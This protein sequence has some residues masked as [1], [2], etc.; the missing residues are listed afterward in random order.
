MFN[1]SSVHGPIVGREK[2]QDWSRIALVL[3]MSFCAMAA[4]AQEQPKYFEQDVKDSNPLR[5]EQA[6]EL[7]EYILKL[8]F[9]QSRLKKL[10]PDDYS[11]VAAYE[12]SAERYRQAF[13]D[14]IGYPPPGDVPSTE[15]SFRQIGEDSLG[16][17]YRVM[18]PVL[19][20]VHAEGIYIIPKS[21][22][23][24]E[25]APLI[26]SMHGGGGSM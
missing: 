14:S 12:K 5:A 19:P 13:C 18:I 22:K 8:K 17:Y 26:I 6:K 23:P 16:T 9:D 25:K 21:L 3:A 4:S 10:L 2:L 24:G 1:P 11:S 15:P 20:M 7:D